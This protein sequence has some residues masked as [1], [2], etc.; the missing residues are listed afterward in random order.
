MDIP[1]WKV[2]A[3]TEFQTCDP[4]T[5]I[6]FDLQP[7]RICS[8]SWFHIQVATTL[9]NSFATVTRKLS[10]E[11]SPDFPRACT[12]YHA[13]S[14]WLKSEEFF[15]VFYPH[16]LAC[17]LLFLHCFECLAFCFCNFVSIFTFF[18]IASSPQRTKQAR[19]LFTGFFFYQMWLPAA[20]IWGENN[21]KITKQK[22]TNAFLFV[23][24]LPS[25]RFWVIH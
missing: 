20:L 24:L 5:Q 7:Y 4:P 22:A 2:P 6:S 10:G 8:F 16:W 25:F 3:G 19:L 21:Q 23:S 15:L 13:Q 11:H 17:F 12:H 1:Q 18:V 9:G 14:F